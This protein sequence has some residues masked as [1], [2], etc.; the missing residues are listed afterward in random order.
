[1]H[2]GG[3]GRPDLSETHH[4]G[5]GKRPEKEE[6]CTG[7]GRRRFITTNTVGGLIGRKRGGMRGG[8]VIGAAADFL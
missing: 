4:K 1:M 5:C 2:E 6:L 3:R 7:G 8:T